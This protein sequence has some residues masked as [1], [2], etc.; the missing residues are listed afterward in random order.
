[1]LCIYNEV[2]MMGSTEDELS[3][4]PAFFIFLSGKDMLHGAA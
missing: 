2:K 3:L 1:M 4:P